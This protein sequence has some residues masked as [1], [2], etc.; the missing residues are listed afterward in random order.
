[1]QDLSFPANWGKSRATRSINPPDSY[2][3]PQ[4]IDF[5]PNPSVSTLMYLDSAAV[6]FCCRIR[7]QRGCWYS[8][9]VLFDLKKLYSEPKGPT[10]RVATFTQRAFVQSVQGK[11]RCQRAT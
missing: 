11:K 10:L 3:I 9:R 8:S 1:M 5:R 4:A 7:Y 6:K 2:I